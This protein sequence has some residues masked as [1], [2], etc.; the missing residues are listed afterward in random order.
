M[1]VTNSNARL[2]AVKSH[3]IADPLITE[4]EINTPHSSGSKV[5]ILA[6]RLVKY[7]IFD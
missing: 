4:S 1:Y 2:L 3:S 5:A 7:I 6:E